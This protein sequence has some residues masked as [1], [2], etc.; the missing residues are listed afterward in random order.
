MTNL[1]QMSRESQQEITTL[2][3]EP[4][5]SISGRQGPGLVFYP[6]IGRTTLTERLFTTADTTAT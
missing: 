5:E 3:E 1:V 6:M 4:L 2:I